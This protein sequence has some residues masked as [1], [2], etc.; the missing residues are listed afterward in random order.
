MA[1]ATPTLDDLIA[2]AHRVGERAAREAQ[3]ADRDRRLSD[4]LI[5]DMLDG[6][7]IS[8]LQPRH[9]GGFELS[10]RDYVEICEIVARYDVAASWV[11]MILAVHHWW[12]ALASPQLQAE[13]WAADPHRLFADV[14]APVGRIEAVDGGVVLSGRWSFASGVLWSEYM[15]LGAI[16]PAERG[17]PPEYLMCFVPKSD[18]RVVD[19]WDT[20]G[21]RGTAS[22]TVEVERAFVP[23]HRLVPL[24]RVV[25]TGRA[26]GH[27]LHAG[28][29]YHLPFGPALAIALVPTHVGALRGAVEEFQ[30][31]M[32]KRTALFTTQ[33][34]DETANAQLLVAEGALTADAC[35]ALMYR[36]ADALMA[37]PADL[38]GAAALEFRLRAFGWRAWIGRHTREHIAT[39]FTHAGASAIYAGGSLQKRW[40]DIHAMAQHVVINHEVGVGAWGRH[41]AGQP[42]QP[43]IY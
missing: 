34:M 10:F 22:C 23:A 30:A 43:G 2:A 24:A 38:D 16:G 33:R 28:H 39:L 41:L 35:E 32:Q 26:P 42:A 3:Q 37:L 4:G 6:G 40:R 36:Y 7:L 13:L 17:A 11:Q 5:A 12:G 8:L 20:V 9:W 18:Y 25:E 1:G 14:F 21:L 31:R 29:I 27:A 15:A 19:D